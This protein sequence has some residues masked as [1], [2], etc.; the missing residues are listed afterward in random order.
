MLKYT[1]P[2]ISLMVQ[3][4]RL[5]TPNAGGPGVIPGQGTV[6]DML[7]PRVPMLQQKILHAVTKTQCS[8]IKK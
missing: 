2:R 8:Q 7:Q 1:V 3:W 5:H 4:L 6:S